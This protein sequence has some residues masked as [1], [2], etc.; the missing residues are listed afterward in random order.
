MNYSDMLEDEMGAAEMKRY[1]AWKE[2]IAMP[3]V[4]PTLGRDRRLPSWS[5]PYAVLENMAW[6]MR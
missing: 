5:A 4:F 3:E 6:S 2:N 1:A